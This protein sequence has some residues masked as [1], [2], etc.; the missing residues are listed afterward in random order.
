MN[1]NACPWALVCHEAD[2]GGNRVGRWMGGALKRLSAWRFWFMWA[3]PSCDH[4]F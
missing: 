1:E 4:E 2:E 3:L